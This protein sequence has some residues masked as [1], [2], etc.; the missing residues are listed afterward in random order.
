M[1][2]QRWASLKG[3]SRDPNRAGFLM[4]PSRPGW[5]RT[6][7]GRWWGQRDVDRAKAVV[8]EIGRVLRLEL[9]TEVGMRGELETHLSQRRLH[10]TPGD[11]AADSRALVDP[12]LLKL[13]REGP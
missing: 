3:W 7:D 9:E 4:D 10:V 1:N 13:L 8:D 5:A 6:S 12:V 2:G 11:K